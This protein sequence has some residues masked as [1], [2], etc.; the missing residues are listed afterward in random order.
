MNIVLLPVS[1]FLVLLVLFFSQNGLGWQLCYITGNDI[2]SWTTDSKIKH[3]TDHK[4]KSSFK[5]YCHCP[6]L[7]EIIWNNVNWK[8][9]FWT[10]LLKYHQIQ[11]IL[12]DL[13]NYAP[14]LSILELHSLRPINVPQRVR[15][16]LMHSTNGEFSGK[17]L[18]LFAHTKA[19]MLRRH[20]LWV[21]SYN[22]HPV[23]KEQNLNRRSNNTRQEIVSPWRSVSL[24]ENLSDRTFGAQLNF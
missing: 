14:F 18:I 20:L 7:N 9:G 19:W 21:P 1:I 24:T 12:C 22:L 13:F 11:Y 23:G 3:C 2:I 8:I 6:A 10:S 4:N 16:F 15:I 17:W 5:F